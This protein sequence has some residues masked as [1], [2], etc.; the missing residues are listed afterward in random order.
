MARLLVIDDD[1][2]TLTWMS[3]ALEDLGHEVRGFLSGHDAMGALASWC[4]N[5]IVA[6]I[7]M[8]EMDGLTFARLVRRYRDVPV[9]FVSIAHKRAEAILS[10][11]VG[12]VQKPATAREVRE[13]VEA[14]LGHGAR[15]NVILVVDDDPDL[16]DL[17][18]S[19]LEPGF[20][21][22]EA[23]HGRRALQILGR[24]PVDLA[25]VDVHMPIMNGV[26]L[27]RAIRRD[28]K[29]DRLPIIVQTS[30]QTA[31]E[32]PVWRDLQVAQLVNKT[33]FM[34]WLNAQIESHTQLAV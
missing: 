6:D 21:V 10:G 32:A 23:E 4:P 20:V 18:R 9:M 12:Y 31:L 22:L 29:L 1:E 33:D 11:A 5:L 2:A 8:P 19:V 15:R 17:Y 24:Q 27:I 13:A 26:E 25:I 16:R 7:L 28:S 34:Q 14:V 3:A 30:D